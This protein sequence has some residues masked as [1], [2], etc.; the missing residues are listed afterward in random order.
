M[1]QEYIPPIMEISE[2][3]I[4]DIVCTSFDVGD[5][6]WTQKGDDNW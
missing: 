1:K 4:E 5:T 2:L 3:M 6:D